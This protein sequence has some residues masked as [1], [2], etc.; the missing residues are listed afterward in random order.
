[1]FT[2]AAS[3][4]PGWSGL[5]QWLRLGADSAAMSR[6]QN[7]LMVV[8]E[9]RRGPRIVVWLVAAASVVLVIAG[10]RF[11]GYLVAPL[12]LAFMLAVILAPLVRRLEGLGLPTWLAVIAVLLLAIGLLVGFLFAAS[13]Q[14][15]EVSQKLPEYQALLAARLDQVGSMVER[16]P[17]SDPALAETASASSAALIQTVAAALS[18]L[19]AGI[20]IVVFFLFLLCLL[21]ASEHT[22]ERTL[23]RVVPVGSDFHRRLD[24]Y[25]R[26]VQMQ[27]RI[28]GVSNL[29]TAAVL[30]VLFLAFRIDFAVL[31]GSL[32]LV[33]GFIPNIGLILACLPA[34]ILAF[35]Q[36][37]FGTALAVVVLGIILNA[38]VD[39][40]VI[41]RFIS[42]SAELPMVIVFL[43][44]IF[45]GW[46]FG[47]LGAIISVP[48]TIL[49]RTLLDSTPET[50]GLA[51][52]M[53]LEPRAPR[54][55]P[56]R[57]DPSQQTAQPEG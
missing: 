8:Q 19:L 31:W 56:Q 48:A 37:G 30:T 54:T 47:L 42:R 27:G 34:V 45:W 49:V 41:P 21:L 51:Q 7:A 16:K 23:R 10:L 35:I 15:V 4:L 50:R 12:F 46:M 25:V 14:L 3:F 38:T 28:R 26:R 40:L 29:L 18:G 55:R 2:S 53:T 52:L 36:F 33:L 32:A 6:A 20:V 44:F 24:E 1:M 39:N 9:G 13:V 5:C 11:T 43:G 17:P 57:K 22:F